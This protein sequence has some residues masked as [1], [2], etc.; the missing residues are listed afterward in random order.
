MVV[1]IAIQ[2]A[3][4]PSTFSQAARDV[5]KLYID[6]SFN[7]LLLEIS[8]KSHYLGLSETSFLIIMY[9]DR[10]VENNSLIN[11]FQYKKQYWNLAEF[12]S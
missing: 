9:L 6:T 3:N 12:I 5:V 1:R 11:V 10:F 7:H 8:G 4:M 2:C